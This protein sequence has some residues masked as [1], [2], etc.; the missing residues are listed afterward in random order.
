[1]IGGFKGPIIDTSTT[2][3]PKFDYFSSAIDISGGIFKK[4]VMRV[5]TGSNKGSLVTTNPDGQITNCQDSVII[6]NT[7]AD[8]FISQNKEC[9]LVGTNTKYENNENTIVMGNDN[10]VTGTKNSLIVGNNLDVSFNNL[11]EGVVALGVGDANLKVT[12]NDRIVLATK[13][14]NNTAVKA[15]SLIHI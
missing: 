2:A 13:D 9:I 7:P 12:G 4:P 11:T 3:H 6:G 14:G 1:M 8:K 10:K 15:L 5:L